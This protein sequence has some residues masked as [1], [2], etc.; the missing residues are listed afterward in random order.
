MNAGWID[1]NSL[2]FTYVQRWKL[3]LSGCRQVEFLAGE[4]VRAMRSFSLAQSA[5]YLGWVIYV[6]FKYPCASQATYGV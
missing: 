3:S 2:F 4:C 1:R 6:S 5:L